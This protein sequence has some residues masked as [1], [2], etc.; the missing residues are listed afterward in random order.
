MKIPGSV[1][2]VRSNDPM[3]EV[4]KYNYSEKR[5]RILSDLHAFL[6]KIATKRLAPAARQNVSP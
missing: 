5:R 3:T 6:A 1:G 2:S 4:T